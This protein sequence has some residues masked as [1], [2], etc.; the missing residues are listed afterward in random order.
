MTSQASDNGLSDHRVT[1]LAWIISATLGL[2]A[3]LFTFVTL[4]VVVVYLTWLFSIPD[5][6]GY[7]TLFLA[8][9][10]GFYAFYKIF[11]IYPY[12]RHYFHA[13]LL[14]GLI[15][16]VVSGIVYWL[17]KSIILF[18]LV[19]FMQH[20]QTVL[21]FSFVLSVLIAGFAGYLCVIRIYQLYPKLT[22]T[23]VSPYLIGFGLLGSLNGLLAY[24]TIGLGW[25]M[26]CVGF[27][28]P[29]L[30]VAKFSKWEKDKNL[31]EVE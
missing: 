22:Y 3:F 25:Y 20:S 8:A 23:K 7:I 19:S 18:M 5:S 9:V 14:S 29:L 15:A 30:T 12:K 11:T 2:A 17:C 13:W 27:L 10:L 4:S 16:G 28:F 21:E 26:A 1:P 24:S 31:Y 6:S